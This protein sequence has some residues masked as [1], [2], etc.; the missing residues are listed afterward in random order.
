MKNRNDHRVGYKKTKVGWI[1]ED[2]KCGNFSEIAVIMMGQ[3]PDGK[4]YNRNKEG[5]P[6]F[7]G[8]TEFTR[9]YPLKKQW[10]INPTKICKPGDILLCVRGSSTGRVNI[11]DC[12]YCIGR[13]IAA[14]SEKKSRGFSS[15][16]EHTL[17]SITGRILRL[18]SGST[19]PNLDKKNL[20]NILIAIPPLLE[21]KKIAEILSAWDETI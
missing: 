19:F 1:P 4:N 20:S 2:W 18:S 16:V 9:R 13:E 3:S 11:A 6:L 8:P 21:Q 5:L 7:N 17:S 15:F 14:V 10:T 12:P